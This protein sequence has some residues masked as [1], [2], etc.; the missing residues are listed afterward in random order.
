[1]NVKSMRFSIK[2]DGKL[3]LSASRTRHV[4]RSKTKINPLRPQ[5][6]ML[7]SSIQLSPPSTRLP[8]L[9]Q[10]MGDLDLA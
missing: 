4:F 1:M 5:S 8:S 9:S 2:S 6:P 7:D 3:T 10:E